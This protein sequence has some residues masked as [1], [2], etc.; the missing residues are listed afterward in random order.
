[1]SQNL[2]DQSIQRLFTKINSESKLHLFKN[3]KVTLNLSNYFTKIKS[4]DARSSLSKLRLGVL[5]LEV[6]KGREQNLDRLDRFCKLC[7]SQQVENEVHF[8]FE[9]PALG[10]DRAPFIGSLTSHIPSFRLLDN[11]QRIQKLYFNEQITTSIQVIS[12]NMLV[13]LLSA[14]KILLDAQA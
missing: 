2:K 6:E 1:M 9:C 4:R 14:R 11:T 12:A 8:L 10:N 7:N 5:P 13:H 3:T